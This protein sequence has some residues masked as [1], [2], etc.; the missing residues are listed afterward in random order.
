MSK[1]YFSDEI[2]L[3]KELSL[4]YLWKIINLKTVP[5]LLIYHYSPIKLKK[6][7]S[8]PPELFPEFIYSKF[9]RR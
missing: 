4:T 7:T 2:L 3:K 5:Y 1:S 9:D 6:K 8:T